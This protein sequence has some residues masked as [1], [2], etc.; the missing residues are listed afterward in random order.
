MSSPTTTNVSDPYSE[1]A[2]KGQSSEGMS[3]ESFLASLAVAAAVF[4][5]EVLLF[6]LLRTKLQRVYVPRTY[7]VPEKFVPFMIPVAAVLT[8]VG[9][10][11]RPLAPASSPGSSPSLLPPI[12]TLS[13]SLASMPTFSFATS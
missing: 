7:L 2:G 8:I 10:A 3:L 4:G 12:A 5:V 1:A 6:V 11:Q 13:T 9:G